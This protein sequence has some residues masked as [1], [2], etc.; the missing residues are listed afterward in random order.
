[1]KNVM[2]M[3]L[4]KVSILPEEENEAEKDQTKETRT[5]KKDLSTLLTTEEKV[6]WEEVAPRNQEK[7]GSRQMGRGTAISF[8]MELSEGVVTARVSE[9]SGRGDKREVEQW[10]IE[11]QG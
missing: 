5:S 8:E 6:Q 1:M 2:K 9:C 11:E 3:Y 4:V 7:R 10:G